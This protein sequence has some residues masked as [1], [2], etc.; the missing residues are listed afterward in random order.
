MLYSTVNNKLKMQ[1]TYK[2]Y[3][4]TGPEILPVKIQTF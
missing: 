4:K 1:I 2:L 3:V